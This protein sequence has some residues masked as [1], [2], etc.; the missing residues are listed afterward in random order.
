MRKISPVFI[1]LFIAAYTTS[2][3]QIKKGSLFL[4]GDLSLSTV[5]AKNANDENTTRQNSFNI[6]PVAGIAVK[7]NFIAGVS[8]NAGFSENKNPYQA[9]QKGNS[10]GAGVFA[11]HYKNIGKSGFYV[12][13]QNSLGAGYGEQRYEKTP[14]INNDPEKVKTFS[15]YL[16][17]YPGLSYAVSR[18]LHL[19]AGFNNLLYLNYS[20][21]KNEYWNTATTKANRF[22]LGTSLNNLSSL[23]VGF[24]VLIG[25]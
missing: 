15:A 9:T 19:E 3:A 14:D 4:G 12:F 22:Y 7:D 6:S 17:L 10:F 1:L 24:R 2:Q 23:Y 16:N 5:N 20:H 11:R 18:K 21:D 13:V 25:K 8:L